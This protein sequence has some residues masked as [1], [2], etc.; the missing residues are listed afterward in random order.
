MT[1]DDQG[2][3][4]PS[5]FNASAIPRRT[6]GFPDAK[7]VDGAMYNGLRRLSLGANSLTPVPT[8]TGAGTS[9]SKLPNK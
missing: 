6:N 5:L 3:S 9:S 8:S 7:L 1:N 4:I 2:V